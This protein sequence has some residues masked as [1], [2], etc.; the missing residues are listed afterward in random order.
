MSEEFKSD[1]LSVNLSNIVQPEQIAQSQTPDVSVAEEVAPD[2]WYDEGVPGK[3][4]KPDYLI[5][6]YGY[7]QAK[8]AKGYKDAEKLVGALK[9][10]PDEY[11]FD[12]VQQDIDKSNEHIQNFISFAKENKIQQ[13]QFNKIMHTLVDYERSKQPN[14]SEE[15][16]KLG[17]DGTQKINTL[18]NWVKNNLTAEAQKAL[19]KLPVRAEVVQML[20]EVRQLHLNSLSKIPPSTQ[21]ESDFTPIT[22]E[23]VEAEML[24][25]YGKYQTDPGYRAQILAKLE[26]LSGG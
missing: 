6:K 14:R 21:K 17:I 18:Q 11:N 20:D 5:E 8:Q 9:P 1:D 4:P 22:K 19:E 15:I 10:A 13:D 3:G 25:N 24:N 2:W 23:A 12:E 26:L 7:N 16:A